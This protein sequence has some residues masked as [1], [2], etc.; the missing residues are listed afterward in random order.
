MSYNSLIFNISHLIFSV[1]VFRYSI[2]IVLNFEF[3]HDITTLKMTKFNNVDHLKL[4]QHYQKVCES[5]IR[6]Q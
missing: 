6:R 4:S 5:E 1:L 3:G 2:D